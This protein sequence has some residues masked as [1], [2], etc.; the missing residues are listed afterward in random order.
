MNRVAIMMV[1]GLAA[2]TAISLG[3]SLGA[4]A[5]ATVSA[6]PVSANAVS[7]NAVSAKAV[8]AQAVS[9]KAVSAKAVAS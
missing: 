8:S 4:S 3:P 6:N 9:A 5:Q 1:V 7:A 2:L